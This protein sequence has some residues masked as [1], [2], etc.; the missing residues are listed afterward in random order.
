MD[1]T[2]RVACN[3]EMFN[4]V[5][6]M[7]MQVAFILVL[8]H[9]FQLVLK[10]LGQPGPIAQI[11]SG[12]VL[13]PSGLSHISFVKKIF[14][15]D[16]TGDYYET[17][18][19]F[20]RIIIM[21]LIGLETDIPYLVRNL[22][23]ASILACGGCVT[24]TVF[25]AAI[26]PF[27]YH[28]T[29]A[30]GPMFT[31]ALTI[32]VIFSNAA[33]PI[34]IRLA[35]E[36]KFA[37]TDFGRLVISSSLISDMYSVVLLV[38]S[39]E[40]KAEKKFM[41]WVLFGCLAFLLVVAVI[42]LNMYLAN[43]LNRRNRNQK[44]LK[45]AE[46][47][48]ILSVLV[49]TAMTI[50]SMGFNSIV[51]C[52]LIG[53]MFPKGGKTGR[54]LLPKLNYSVH[55]FIFPIYLGYMGFQ[56]DM[57]TINSLASLGVVAVVLLLSLGG[58]ISGTLAACYYLRIPMNE[59]T[60]T[61]IV[62]PIIVY[63]VRRENES[64]GYRHVALEWQDPEIE[65]RMLACVHNPRHVSTIVG[66][67][68]AL[69]GSER[70]P[71]TPYLMHLIE[72]PDQKSKDNSLMYH[73][74]EDDELSDE[75]NYGG[76]EVVEINE[77][78]DAFTAETGV[79]VHQVKAVSPFQNMHDDV[80]ARAEETRASIILLH[81]HKHQRIDG[82]MEPG[83]EGI[84]TTNQKVLRHSKCS[85]AI[86][87]DRGLTNSVAATR[88]VGGYNG[89]V[90]GSESLQH[91]ATLFFGGPD[92]REALGFSRRLSMHHHINLTIIRFLA[93]A[94]RDRNVGLNVAHNKEEEEDVLM[95]SVCSSDRETESEADTAILT[96]FYNRYVTSGQVGYVEKYVETGAE[97]AS[98]LRDMADMYSLFIVG[99][100]GRG[101]S[102]LTT[103]MSD[104]EECP[105][106]GTVGDL[107]GSSDFDL[108]GSVLVIQQH[109]I[110]SSDD[111]ER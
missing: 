4:P 44:H 45:N 24:C 17:M 12:F 67:I 10:P 88:G 43:W 53:S 55:N 16:L 108:S 110:S 1:A 64:L 85:V 14:F 33:S 42:I 72:L 78:V 90:S 48:G 84:R 50:E 36:L 37:T 11:L 66:L 103:G 101:H 63:I 34:V 2:K 83:K 105:E 23:P 74:R 76:N 59:V 95:M 79:V 106:L 57:T 61:L 8:S 41:H 32:A 5:S 18:A 73:Q 25:A 20:S 77:A 31:M 81:F 9:C 29:G 98:A 65:L 13:G 28:Q 69:R 49:V 52:F 111:D 3:R 99:K 92:D 58:K 100:G 68:A 27:I 51:A 91:V 60:N 7:G 22:R 109:R 46:A 26:T 40:S 82:K 89:S 54:T 47:F 94:D 87:V 86:L 39:S 56:A 71:I 70:G 104:W 38:V 96:E 107:L 35:A 19:L 97:T 6:T 93:A 102:P 75:D 30:H 80:C 15:Q 21:F 62:G